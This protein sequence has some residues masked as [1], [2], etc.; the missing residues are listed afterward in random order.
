MKNWK[1][2]MLFNTPLKLIIALG[3]LILVVELFI[4]TVISD[5]L[6]PMNIPGVYWNVIDAALLTLI[7]SPALYSLIFQKLQSEE[8]FRQINASAQDAIVI[9][10]EQGRFTDWNPAA[11]RMFQYSR[12]EALG[13]Q[14]HQLLAPPRY[15]A[16]A[17]R[18]FTQFQKT[19]EGPLIGKIWE[20]TAIRKDGSEFPIEIY[21]SALKEKGRWHA[22]GIMRDITGRKQAETALR[23]LNEGLEEKVKTRTA[24]LERARL[25]AEQANH[26]KSDFLAT[27]SHEI[28]TPMNGVIGM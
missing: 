24:D 17:A 1:F 28:R 9:V 7:I 19:G 14:M 6:S 20:V 11:Q 4:M 26:A 12:E 10:D 5:A 8:R 3:L 22:V 2:P 23:K 18:G 25:D 15:H 13:Q 21:I 16:D 27:M